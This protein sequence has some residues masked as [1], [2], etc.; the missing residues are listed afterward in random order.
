MC[1]ITDNVMFLWSVIKSNWNTIWHLP[2][3]HSLVVC[4]KFVHLLASIHLML[5]QKW[6]HEAAFKL[7]PFS[8][9]LF[10]KGI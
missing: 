8:N 2:K 1:M 10:A 6:S 9:K 7:F 3:N 5:S 4:V